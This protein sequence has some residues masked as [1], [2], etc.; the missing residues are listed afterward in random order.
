MTYTH[1]IAEQ[2]MRRIRARLLFG[3]NDPEREAALAEQAT[4]YRR[5]PD[6]FTAPPSRESCPGDTPYPAAGGCGSFSG[7]LEPSHADT[8][9]A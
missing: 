1:A 6:L 5:Q 3:W 2:H 4:F 7:F 8:H 9:V